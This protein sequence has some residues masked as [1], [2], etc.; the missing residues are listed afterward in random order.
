MEE[1]KVEDEAEPDQGGRVAL[2]E[3]AEQARRLC[4]GP[5]DWWFSAWGGQFT[6]NNVTGLIVEIASMRQALNSPE[7]A[8]Q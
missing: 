5:G 7:F 6:K 2:R 8:R 1:E 3:C 4:F